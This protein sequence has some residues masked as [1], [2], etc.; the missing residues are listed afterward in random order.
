MSATQHEIEAISALGADALET[1]RQVSR[2]AAR[3]L[4]RGEADPRLHA[5]AAIVAAQGPACPKCRC[6]VTGT[7]P[8]TCPGCGARVAWSIETKLI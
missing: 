8:A 1:L 4:A 2:R 3:L 6:N 7:S 5:L